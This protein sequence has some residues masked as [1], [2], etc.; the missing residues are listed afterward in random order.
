M[1]IKTDLYSAQEGRESSASTSAKKGGRGG[2]MYAEQ[3]GKL[4]GIEEGPQPNSVA[5][6]AE[7]KKLQE[8]KKKNWAEARKFKKM[9]KAIKQAKPKIWSFCWKEGAFLLGFPWDWEVA[10]S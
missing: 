7:K 8:Q 1:A 10:E 6:V 3:K 5:M 9:Q 4:R 2:G